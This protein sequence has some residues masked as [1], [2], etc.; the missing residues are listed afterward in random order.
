M[1][2]E[3]VAGRIRNQPG[4]LTLAE[5]GTA[6]FPPAAANQPRVV[7]LNSS[8]KAILGAQQT[9]RMSSPG[10]VF[11]QG[12]HRVAVQSAGEDT[13]RFRMPVPTSS[14]MFYRVVEP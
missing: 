13:V 9:V 12:W 7:A 2:L 14:P 5:S 8:Q 1:G 11:L 10:A 6:I 3:P 4:D